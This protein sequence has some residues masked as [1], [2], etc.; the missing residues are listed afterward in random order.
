MTTPH[1]GPN[2]VATDVKRIGAI[3]FIGIVCVWWTAFD[4]APISPGYKS[5]THLVDNQRIA[6]ALKLSVDGSRYKPS[7]L[8][9][10][11]AWLIERGVPTERAHDVVIN[12]MMDGIATDEISLF[13]RMAFRLDRING[14][15]VGYSAFKLANAFNGP[16]EDIRELDKELNFLTSVQFGQMLD[17]ISEGDFPVARKIG[18]RAI[19]S[20]LDP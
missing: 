20:R 11:V 9:G 5:A 10:A 3:A 16:A 12:L 2:T 14:L 8:E 19:E 18:L 6:A 4:K 15:G 13:A 7:N 1:G 17:A